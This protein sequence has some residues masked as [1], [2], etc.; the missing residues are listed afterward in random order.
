LNLLIIYANKKP[1]ESSTNAVITLQQQKGMKQTLSKILIL[2]TCLAQTPEA[3]LDVRVE[4][5]DGINLLT[6]IYLPAGDGPFPV[7]L[8]RV[9]YGTQSD[10]I[11]QSSYGH[12]F[13]EQGYVYV[14]QNVR[15]RFGSEGEFATYV[16]GQEI[17]DAYDTI[18]WIIDQ[19][20]SDGNVGVMGESYYGYTTLMAAVSGHTA[21][22]AISP[23]TITLARE[24]QSID[25]VLPLQ[26]SGMW[27]LE[28]DDAVNGEYQDT[29]QIDL[30]HIP[31][32]TMGQKYG[33][34]DNLWRER[35]SGYSE[36]PIAGRKSSIDEYKKIHVPTLHFGGWYD[37]F[38]R[39]T[40]ALWNGIQEYSENLSAREMQ[41]LV[42]GP[43]DHESL[44]KHLSGENPSSRIGK[45]DFGDRAMT[46]Y[47]ETLVNFFDH[48]L[49]GEDNGF[50]SR[51]RVAY[52]NIGDNDWRYTDQWPPEQSILESY[53]LQKGGRLTR[54]TPA[55]SSASTYK[56]DPQHPVV[57][58]GDI[59]VW[60][61]AKGMKDRRDLP[62][63]DD[64][65]AFE[66]ESI[67]TDLEITGPIVLE[68]FASSS[69]MDTDF[70]G[71]LV[72]VHPDGYSL[73]IQEGILRASFRDKN[74]EPSQIIPGEVYQFNI[75]LWATSYTLPAGHRLRLE[76]S[77]S[78]F[79]RFARNLN[80]AEP[81]GMSDKIEVA[82]QTIY[83]STQ[84]PSHLLLPVMH[85]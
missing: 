73:L 5:R 53:Y 41:W 24:K 19:E 39:G 77:S 37:T 30:F 59:N 58:T 83:H 21:I 44:S 33:L 46:T 79:P 67:K 3:Q 42:L 14:S 29:Q 10:Y 43:W 9:P 65:L 12:Y 18:D 16:N 22:K 80:N 70:T 31:L 82:T 8:S 85:R 66:T 1:R 23:A 48:F 47:G 35:I 32:I 69:A 74:T 6:D 38:T 72:D 25:G 61:R 15:G 62:L 4:M 36:A 60:E 20:W 7:I 27:T 50:A 76:I 40:I 51:E 34:R 71:A 84:F 54:D 55:N 17:P 68:L 75:D 26:A 49:K 11:F 56:Y 63:R 2:T 57:I 78:N 64:V 45:R 81:F 52:F 28:M 13:T